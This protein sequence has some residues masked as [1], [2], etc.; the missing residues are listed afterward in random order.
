MFA[1]RR[2]VGVMGL[3]DV[4]TFCAPGFAGPLTPDQQATCDAAS[5]Y[6]TVSTPQGDYQIVN[7]KIFDP[8]GNPVSGIPGGPTPG[9]PVISNT[10]VLAAAGIAGLFF[11]M[12][13][14]KR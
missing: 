7:G 11:I 13:M 4:P 2:A 8:K 12:A 10:V 1:S 3:G 6:Q 9:T 14:I 5:S